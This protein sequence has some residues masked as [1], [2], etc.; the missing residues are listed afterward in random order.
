MSFS[1]GAG[2]SALERGFAFFTGRLDVFSS[3]SEEKR[4]LK[5]L[6]E[7]GCSAFDLRE[8]F[9]GGEGLGSEETWACR[10]DDAV[11]WVRVRF[12]ATLSDLARAFADCADFSTAPARRCFSLPAALR[13]AFPVFERGGTV[14][15]RRVLV[16]AATRSRS[17]SAP[18]SESISK[19]T[20]V[21]KG[22]KAPT[23]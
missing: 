16:A 3:S 14:I 6:S 8:R 19:R 23:A 20:E 11:G 12:E 4:D 13:V 18:P 21:R 5:T 22:L 7:S 17:S 2:R 9:R 1:S 15:L 10:E